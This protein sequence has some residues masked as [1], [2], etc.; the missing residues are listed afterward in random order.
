M[1]SP[2]STEQL[3]LDLV[4][5]A[6]RQQAVSAIS[7]GN[8]RLFLHSADNQHG[9][10]LVIDNMRALMDAGVFEEA[11]L[12]AFV[13]CRVNHHHIS[14]SVIRWMFEM[15]DHSRL[16][17]QGDPLSGVSK[18]TLYRGVAGIGRA[19][20]V[21]G[22]SWTDDLEIAKWFA[23]RFSLP[24][25]GVYETVVSADQ[26]VVFLHET[27]RKEREY[28]VIPW[29]GMKVRRIWGPGSQTA[30]GGVPERH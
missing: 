30:G 22:Y 27:G 13:G 19:R 14:P 16:R 15:A 11:L 23:H 17:S 10:H 4:P 1:M 8:V 5:V 26:V 25:P 9:L 12:E 18:L 6:L 7:T 24:D 29:A 2:L 21:R 20:R 28:I 3:Q